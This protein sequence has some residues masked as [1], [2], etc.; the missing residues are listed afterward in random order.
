M[1]FWHIFP[2]ALAA[3]GTAAFAVLL[4]RHRRI[5]ARHRVAEAELVESNDTLNRIRQ[6]MGS[7][8]DA[9]GIGDFDGN[10][11]YHNRSWMNLF[12][13]TV[14]ELNAVPGQGV[15]FADEEVAKVV[16][17]HI[18]AGRSWAGEADIRTKDG[19]RIPAA[20]RT[21]VV[22]DEKGYPVGIFGIFRDITLERQRAREAER[23][24]EMP[25]LVCAAPLR[26][27]L[28]KLTRTAAPRL[29]V[30]SYAELGSQL[31]LDTRGVVDLAHATV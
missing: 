17:E 9:I 19:R 29:P 21:D 10:S 26:P 13:Y 8:T 6:A 12:G 23:E 4:S 7:A 16:Y 30:L 24:G 1:P 15:L 22:L 28:R 11:L 3:I 5:A 14:D 25:V 31:R 2:W 18:N 27:A 20:I